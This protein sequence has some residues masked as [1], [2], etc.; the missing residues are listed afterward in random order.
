MSDSSSKLPITREDR[1]FALANL[2]GSRDKDLL[3][4]AEALA[5][6]KAT[7]RTNEAVGRHVGVSGEIVRQFLTLRHF[8]PEVQELMHRRQLGLED[9]RRLAQLQ[10]SRPD[11]LIPVAHR[12]TKISAHDGRE[13]V[14]QLISHPGMSEAEAWQRIADAK[15][16]TTKEFHVVA[17]LEE[18]QF[19]K[20]T[21]HARKGGMTV[22]RLVTSIVETWLS[23]RE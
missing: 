4:T 22:D 2:K 5:R 8:P 21:S 6:M 7:L 10:K 14:R 16:V 9:G 11:V 13:L 1:A 20:L 3:G 12:M 17:L 18:E 19:K 23:E 15:T